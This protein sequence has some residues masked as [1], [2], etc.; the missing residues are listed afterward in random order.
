MARL[1]YRFGF[2]V[3][4]N[5]LTMENKI[6]LWVLDGDRIS[7]LLFRSLL[8]LSQASQ[9]SVGEL[10]FFLS[11]EEL[12]TSYSEVKSTDRIVMV[13]EVFSSQE[14]RWDI[15][16]TL[17][18][19]ANRPFVAILTTFTTS[20][21]FEKLSRFPCVK[22]IFFKPLLLRSLEDLIAEAMRSAR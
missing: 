5:R 17:S 18:E 11:A 3:F 8:E 14:D 7:H 12:K 19:Y 10:R 1:S 13:I 4:S 9:R 20:E 15:L 2:G 21:D 22:R 6:D 16:Q